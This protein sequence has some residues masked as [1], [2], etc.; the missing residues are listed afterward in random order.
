M[1]QLAVVLVLLL[2]AAVVTTVAQGDRYREVKQ[3]NPIMR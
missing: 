1:Q 3:I 2:V